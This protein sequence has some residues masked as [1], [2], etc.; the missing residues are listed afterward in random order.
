MTEQT[1]LT[2]IEAIN[3][4]YRLKDKYQNEYY[5]KYVKPIIKSNKSKKEKRVEYSKL[6]KHQCINCKRNVGTIFTI[7]SNDSDGIRQFKATCG[8]LQEPCPLD[9]Q[10]DYSNREPMNTNI[11]QGLIEIEKIKLNIIKQKNNSLFFKKNV[12]N[13]FNK[14]TEELKLET[15][16]TGLII[17]TNI[18][19][20]NNPEKSVLLKQTIDEFGKGFILPFKQ[21]VKEF[22]ETNNELVLNQAANFYV[23]EMIPKLKEILL[24]KY[25]VSIVEYDE[26]NNIYKLIQLPNSLESNEFYY[27]DQDK[28]TKFVKGVKKA[29][30]K[31]RKEETEIKPKN[32]TRKIKPIAE[33]VLEDEEEQ[34]IEPGI[35]HGIEPGIEQQLESKY[36]EEPN[37]KPIFDESGNVRWNNEEYNKIWKLMSPQLKS[38]LLED[39]DWLEDYMNSCF[40]LIKEGKP[41]KLF[42][43]KQTKLPP[44]KDA[45]G[46]YEFGSEIVDKLFNGLS[47]SYQD[48]LLTLY[49]EKDGERNYDM[50]RDTLASILAKQINFERGIFGF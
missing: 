10:I 46:N 25:D 28:V 18:L 27:K 2:P 44:T 13:I 40:K 4:F 16:N 1:I 47:K 7:K 19:R 43:P 24:L 22:D 15:E 41:C 11:K 48:I 5:E 17:E 31:T 33:L 37:K 21:M 9:I 42:L 50:L 39:P 8:D 34:I 20:N 32:K 35:E 6:P 45:N 12:V 26:I 30:K 38:L 29:K 49:S 3:E 36:A 14:L 23:N